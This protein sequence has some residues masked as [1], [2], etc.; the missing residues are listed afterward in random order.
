MADHWW[1]SGVDTDFNTIGNWSATQGGASN[2]TTPS[3]VDNVYFSDTSSGNNCAM[4]AN[5]AC[6]HI[7]MDAANTGGTD[8]YSGTLT[9]AGFTMDVYG[10]SLIHI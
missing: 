4:S 10:L 2:G 8:D 1:I 9:D 6:A 3:N 7:A 5:S